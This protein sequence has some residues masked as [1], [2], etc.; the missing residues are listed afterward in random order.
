MTTYIEYDFFHLI[1]HIDWVRFFYT[2]SLPTQ[3]GVLFSFL[4][5]HDLARSQDG[6]IL[7]KV[8]FCV[9]VY[10]PRRN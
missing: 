8:C 9:C 6:G 5:I 3:F 4:V 7:A 10:G 1:Y 2:T